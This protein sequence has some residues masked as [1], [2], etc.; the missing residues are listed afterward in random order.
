MWVIN[1]SLFCLVKYLK[2]I[3][4]MVLRLSQLIYTVVF[5]F[6]RINSPSHS[7]KERNTCRP[8]HV[9]CSKA[10]WFYILGISFLLF[11]LGLLETNILKSRKPKSGC[12]LMTWPCFYADRLY[13]ALPAILL[14]HQ[15]FLS[16]VSTHL[17]VD[18]L[19]MV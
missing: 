9:N 7:R 1:K 13:G 4:F 18:E 8:F 17:S 10:S 11:W 6:T 2:K 15:A 19:L 12:E 14:F 16:F 3:K 5:N